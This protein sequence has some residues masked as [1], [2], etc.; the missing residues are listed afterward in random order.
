LTR[1]SA[2]LLAAV[3]ILGSQAVYSRF[4]SRQPFL[5]TPD[6]LA[7]FPARLNGWSQVREEDIPADALEKLGPDDFVARIYQPGAATGQAE[8]FVAYYRT[9][10]RA[11]NAHN[12]SV[13]LPGAGWNPVD[14]RQ[15]RLGGTGA[16]ALPVNYYRIKK[17]NRERVVLYWFQTFNAVYTLEQE[18]KA[19]RL[20]DAVFSNRTD[21][22]LI[23]IIVPVT[24]AGVPAAD[25]I[26]ADFA[27][28]VYTQMLHY[29][30]SDRT[31][32]L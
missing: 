28:T 14:S 6:S 8:L 3:P 32:K 13:C 9:Q 20:L 15:L 21:M 5:P 16:R 7:S 30:P 22:A 1:R 17:E 4:A 18:L 12:P 23:R 11:K 26:A 29:F 2:L 24:S 31:S 19:H 27:P 25:A 10:L